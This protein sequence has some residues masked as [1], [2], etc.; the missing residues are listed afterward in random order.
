MTVDDILKIGEAYS[1]LGSAVQRQLHQFVSEASTDGLN[2][3]AV[4]LFHTFFKEISPC[5]DDE[6]LLY[7]IEDYLQLSS[8][9]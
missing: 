1:H 2:P 6:Y 8:S 4:K 9:E 5:I 7:D 3:N